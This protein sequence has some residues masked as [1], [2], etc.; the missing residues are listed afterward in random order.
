MALVP[1]SVKIKRDGVEYLN[2]CE[3]C[4]YTLF[5]LICAALRDVGKFVC[6]R[7]RQEFYRTFKRHKGRVGTY[8]QYWVRKNKKYQDTP[9]LVIGIKPG[10]FYGGYQELGTET[11][12]KLGILQKVTLENVE[13]IR[14]IE[15]Q[16][17]TALNQENPLDHISYDVQDYEGGADD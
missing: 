10:G 5:E 1:S 8:C 13:E 14:K 9:D 15:A 16:Y 2:N 4:K 7:F 12:P 6:R 11:Q 17:L 3:V